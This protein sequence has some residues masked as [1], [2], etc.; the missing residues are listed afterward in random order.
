M[1][2]AFWIVGILLLIATFVGVRMLVETSSTPGNNKK[3]ETEATASPKEVY[4]WG[5]FEVEKGIAFLYP[6]QFG[7]VVDVKGEDAKVKVKKGDVLLQVDD[8]LAVFKAREAEVDVRAGETQLEEAKNLTKLYELQAAQQKSAVEAAKSEIE[9]FKLEI[10]SK[11]ASLDEKSPL[12]KTYRDLAKFGHDQLTEKKK[13]EEAKLKQIEL[14]DA[15]LKIKQAKADL[16][17]RQVRWE[18]AKEMVNHFQITAPSDGYVLRVNV[19]KGE[20]LG[21]TPRIHAIEFIPDAPVI[22]RAEVLQ[23]W[24]RFVKEGQEV[25]IEDDTYKGPEW[26][27]T[28]KEVKGWFAPIRNPVIEP[29]RFND[30]RTLECV[31]DVKSGGASPPL[32]GQRVRARIRV[33]K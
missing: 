32:I 4:A 22:V 8:K 15:D 23:E 7:L 13:A 31:I 10:E 33:D 14:Q 16:D 3:D 27:G 28:V 29:F 18:Q 6:R 5:Y 30:V 25:T 19:H 17:A 26:K 11:L 1:K 24:A 12:A 20:T 9:R 2:G 21:P